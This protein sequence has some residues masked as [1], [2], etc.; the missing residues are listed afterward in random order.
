MRPFV[1]HFQLLRDFG[2]PGA[3]HTKLAEQTR[4]QEGE[5]QV[6]VDYAERTHRVRVESSF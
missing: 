3:A 2:F 4:F 5:T 1:F 6:G